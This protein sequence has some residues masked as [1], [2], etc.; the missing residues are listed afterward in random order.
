MGDHP[1]APTGIART[2]PSDITGSIELGLEDVRS[3]CP[4]GQWRLCA[5]LRV[6]LG[7]WWRAALTQPAHCHCYS[8]EGEAVLQQ[9]CIRLER[10]RRREARRCLRE[11]CRTLQTSV[12]AKVVVYAAAP[13]LGE[14]AARGVLQRIAPRLA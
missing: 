5:L 11:G 9:M 2:S 7:A 8:E 12:G 6:I 3:A 4:S 1:T 14:E 13:R 10:W